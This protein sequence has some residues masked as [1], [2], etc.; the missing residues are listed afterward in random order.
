M[1]K[2]RN[3]ELDEK[4]E[5]LQRLVADLQSSGQHREQRVYEDLEKQKADNFTLKELIVE[6]QDKIEELKE[7]ASQILVR[8]GDS[9]VSAL[10]LI[11][12]Y[13]GTEH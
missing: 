5:D 1:V 7:K 2:V 10:D 9:Y 8:I 6:E 3:K 11:Q 13:Q 4:V 12:T